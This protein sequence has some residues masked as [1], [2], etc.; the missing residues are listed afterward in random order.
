MEKKFW[1]PSITSQF[2]HCPIPYHMDTYRGC[3]FNCSY[4]FARDFVTF[5]RRNNKEEHKKAFSYLV[6]NRADLLKNW[7]ERTLKKD[8]DY[9]KPEEVAFK[10]RIPIKIGATAD[11][12]PYLELKYGITKDILKVF[13]EYD[14][15]V[16]IQTKNPEGIYAIAHEFEN[17]NWAIAVT[18]ISTDEEFIKVC[19]PGAQS[20][21]NRL[22]YI[23]K[24]TD[25]GFKVMIKIQPA[26][27][28]KILEDLPKLIKSAKEAGCWAVN[29][30]GLKIRITMPESEKQIVKKMSDFLGYDIIDYYKKNGVITGSDREIKNDS[31][32]EYISDALAFCDIHNIKFFVADNSCMNA[33]CNSE[34][35]GT[36]VLRDYKIWGNNLRSHHFR[37]QDNFSKELGKYKVNFVRSKK[38]EG[39]T[40]DEAVVAKKKENNIKFIGDALKEMKK[41]K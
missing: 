9:N 14:Y 32:T 38:F 29:I 25:M 13:H 41:G 10:E 40:M 30:E 23:K 8:Y 39:K 12:F 26:I 16:E 33:G 22:E 19:E 34:C 35:C 15:P 6:G 17:P 5:S 4:C 20:A 7:I 18:L 37:D 21:S 28:P 31:K 3:S 27:Y 1:K 2:I 11:P 36:E 24:L